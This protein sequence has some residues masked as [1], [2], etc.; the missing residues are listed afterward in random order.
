MSKDKGLNGRVKATKNTLEA[1][2]NL[3]NVTK[4]AA[5]KVETVS[6]YRRRVSRLAS[7]AN[8]R[9]ERLEKNSLTDSPAYKAFIE[10]GGGR[11]GV[12]GKTYNQVQQELSRLNRFLNAE[13][14]TIKGVK[15]VIT[16]IAQNTGIRYKNFKDLKKKSAKFFELASKAEQYLRNVEDAASA[17]GYQKIWEVINTYVDANK[18]DLA[19]SETDLDEMLQSISKALTEFERPTQVNGGFWVELE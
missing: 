12:K 19:D 14:S 16:E 13:T 15:K 8:K 1:L 9:L 18:V 17:I 4:A 3:P 11:F 7:V 5:N 6:E 2:D 10:D